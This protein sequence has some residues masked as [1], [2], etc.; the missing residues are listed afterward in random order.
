MALTSAQRERYSR[1]LIL[2]QIGTEG[3]E[4]LLSARIALVGAGGLGS[5][6]AVYLAAAG[7]GTLGLIDD[8]VVDESN[9]QRQILHSEKTIGISK[10]DSA[11]QRIFEMN[12]EVKIKKYPVRLTSA[13]AMQILSEYDIVVDGCDN[14]PTRYLVNDAC[15]LLGKPDI[16]GALYHFE[17]QASVFDASRG[18]CYRCLF[19]EPPPAGAVPSCE[20]AGVLGI[21]P[22]LIGIVQ[23]TEAIKLVLRLGKPLIGRLLLYDA[24]EMEFR[25]VRLK[26]NPDCP[27]CGEN[28]S[29]KQLIDYEQFCHI[30]SSHKEYRNLKADELKQKL[31]GGET[32]VILDVRNPDEFEAGHIPGARLIPLG[33]LPGRLGE[34]EELRNSELVVYCQK[35]GRSAKACGILHQAGFDNLQNLEGGFADYSR[36][37]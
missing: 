4:K 27:V 8:D 28:P 37:A 6:A 35:G 13:N 7:V 18:P 9:L 2:P 33:E 10:L 31:T 17:G 19:P 36:H 32:P 22:G 23:A 25:S 24:L 1:H 21:L 3:Q 34:I 14:F 5:P 11:E 12:S 29:V 16:Y 26:R 20:E 30:G 15:V